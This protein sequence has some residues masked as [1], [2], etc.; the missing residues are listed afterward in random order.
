VAYEDGFLSDP[1]RF[2]QRLAAVRSRSSDVAERY[3]LAP[4]EGDGAR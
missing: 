2:V 1:D 4:D 3:P